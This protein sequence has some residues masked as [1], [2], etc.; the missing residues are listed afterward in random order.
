MLLGN[1]RMISRWP[2]RGGPVL[3]D[4]VLYFAAGIWP[5]EGVYVYAVDPATGKVLWCNDSSGAID[6]PQPHPGA[7]ARSGVAAQGY[8]AVRGPDLLVSTGRA[9]PA[10]F[11]RT[12]GSLQTFPLQAYGRQGGADIVAFDGQTFNHGML[13]SAVQGVKPQAFGP[14]VAVHP[15]WV[16]SCART[17][18]AC[19]TAES[20]G[21]IVL[22]PI[23]RATRPP[24]RRWDSRPGP[25]N[26]RTPRKPR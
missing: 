19:M 17:S 3:A 14:Q 10:V 1:D 6:M 5:S 25:S 23:A 12:H 2:A 9:V 15:Q 11:D 4:G 24:P 13:Y 21:S 22:R 16:V 26:S 18:S 20:C 7:N 8:L